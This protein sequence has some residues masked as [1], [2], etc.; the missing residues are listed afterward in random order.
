AT[1][2][3]DMGIM[4]PASTRFRRTSKTTA[5][6]PSSLRASCSGGS[7]K[8]VPAC[9][10]RARRGIPRCPNGRIS[11][12]SARSGP[13]SCSC[14]IRRDGSRERGRRPRR[15]EKGEVHDGAPQVHRRGDAGHRRE[16]P[17]PFSLLPPRG[18][19]YHRRQE[20][21]RKSTRLNSSHGSISYAVFCLK[22]KNTDNLASAAHITSIAG[23]LST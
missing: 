12:P 4:P 17:S 21:D 23:E 20:G 10:A 14:T 1:T 6:S 5:P 19:G 9:R 2:S 15:R 18:P 11:S 3:T 8:A 22:K 7:R 16:R 13:W